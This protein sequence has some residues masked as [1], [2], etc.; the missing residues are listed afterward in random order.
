LPDGSILVLVVVIDS[1]HAV[2]V[3]IIVA[4]RSDY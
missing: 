1:D 3:A 4:M 2:L